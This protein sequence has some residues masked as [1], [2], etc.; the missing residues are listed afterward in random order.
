MNDILQNI[1]NY[2]NTHNS[3]ECSKLFVDIRDLIIE[4]HKKTVVC[5]HCK[6]PYERT[7]YNEETGV[8]MYHPQCDCESGGEICR[9]TK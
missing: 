6:T 2:C 8:A 9:D 1:R 4:S 3:E 7:E 5:A